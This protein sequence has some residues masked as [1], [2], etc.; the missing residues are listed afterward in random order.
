MGWP[1]CD[2][3]PIVVVVSVVMVRDMNVDDIMNSSEGGGY[4]KSSTGIISNTLIHLTLSCL[5]NKS[6]TF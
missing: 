1:S 3:E 4:S 2:S 5:S 6:M